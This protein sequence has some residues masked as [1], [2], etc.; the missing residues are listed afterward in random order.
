LI[1]QRLAQG[2][3]IIIRS[4]LSTGPPTEYQAT[5]FLSIGNH[6]HKVFSSLFSF[7]DFLLLISK[8]KALKNK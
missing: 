2:Y 8:K 7:I 1:S 3:Q 5:Y 4:S 6:F